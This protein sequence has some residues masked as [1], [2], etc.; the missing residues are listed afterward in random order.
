MILSKK[1]YSQSTLKVARDLLGKFLVYDSPQ[2]K[3]VGKITETEAYAGLEDR[4]SHASRGLT[5][6]TALMYGEAG[7][8]YIY[9]IYGFYH[10][11][12]VV[13]EAKGYPAAV[14]IR[15]VEPVEGVKI[16]IKNRK[17]GKNMII[18][19]EKLAN[20]PGKLCQ[21]FGI[22]KGLNGSKVFG[23]RHINRQGG[24][25][26]RSVSLFIED[27]GAEIKKSDIAAAKRV[28]VD[29]AG[30]WK[31]KEWRFY[32]RGSSFISKK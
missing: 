12:N 32:L 31:D 16:M 23:H 9:L 22:A 19:A 15:A 28:G 26:S 14:L 29:Y 24:G 25:A 2:G 3:I 8:W 7:R 11:L 17:A 4:A 13:T 6:R 20:G 21:A 10:C 30:E 5:P 27:R 18:S 1:F